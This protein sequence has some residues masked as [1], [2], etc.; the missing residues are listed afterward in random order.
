MV[1][2][3]P[4]SICSN[5]FISFGN[6]ST[7]QLTNDISTLGTIVPAVMP[8]WDDMGGQAGTPNP[9]AFYA[10]TG[11]A[12]NQVFTMEWRQ[13]RWNYSGLTDVINIQCKLFQTTGVI[14]F[15]YSQGPNITNIPSATIGIANSAVDYQTLN[16]TSTAP[17][18][19]ASFTNSLASKP[20]TGQ[21]YQYTPPAPCTTAPT[22]TV[23]GP[24]TYCPN[25]PF[26]LVANTPTPLSGLTYQWESS[27]MGANVWTPIPGATAA[28]YNSPG[29]NAPTDFRVIL[30]CTNATPPVTSTSAT[31]TLTLANFF[32][33]YCNS[34]AT[35][36]VDDDIGNVTIVKQPNNVV[37]LNNGNASPLTNNPNSNNLYT[38]FRNTV[39]AIPL[40]RDSLYRN[41]VTQINSAGFYT[42]TVAA[43]IDYNHSGTFDPLERVLYKITSNV[44][45]PPNQ[46]ND[47]FRVPG[48][49]LLGNTA[50]RF[51]LV[52]GSGVAINPCGT[53][54]W[55]ETED[56]LVNVNFPPCNGPVNP[57]TAYIS[58]T[59]TCP[60]YPIDL[61]D[62]S[63][64][65]LKSFITWDWQQSTNNGAY[66]SNF[67]VPLS[68]IHFLTW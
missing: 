61:G 14:Q 32:S 24:S 64:E 46:V 10:T 8:L 68:R 29:I 2:L 53:Y 31:K 62:T 50:M 35:S 38:D 66:F 42:A 59:M 58:D 15:I 21:V 57:G 6:V 40:F 34:A 18:S 52:E 65:K 51:I 36:T 63:H 44:S 11:T 37:L 26:T 49:A 54:T 67:P 25:Q 17:V 22:A 39:P 55:G 7:T 43:Y 13:W 56:Y 19:S 4:V 47:T 5:G 41:F 9:S 16:N 33:C 48:S 60:G 30:T 45:V 12:P 28:T 27:P 1:R 20:A 3:T 23:T